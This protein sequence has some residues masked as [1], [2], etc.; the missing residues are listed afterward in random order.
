[1]ALSVIHF[2]VAAAV[3]KQHQFRK[4]RGPSPVELRSRKWPCRA[5]SQQAWSKPGLRAG[6]AVGEAGLRASVSSVRARLRRGGAGLGCR[7]P[8][9][10]RSP[11]CDGAGAV[12][13]PSH[14]S[15]YLRVREVEER[16]RP[17]S[18]S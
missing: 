18:L 14:R 6:V 17:R 12:S 8:G 2:V 4:A 10:H 11:R 15:G 3:P 9:H 1:M 7:L 13:T 16:T 5:S